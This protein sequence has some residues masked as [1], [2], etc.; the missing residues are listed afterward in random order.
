MPPLEIHLP[1]EHQGVGACQAADQLQV[2]ILGSPESDSGLA[3]FTDLLRA[4]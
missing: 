1:V 2:T 3:E 4:R